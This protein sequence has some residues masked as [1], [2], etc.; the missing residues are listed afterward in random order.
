MMDT[1]FSVALHTMPARS[2]NSDTLIFSKDLSSS[3]SHKP[4]TTLSTNN[5]SFRFTLSM[6]NTSSETSLT[7]CKWPAHVGQQTRLE[8]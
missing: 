8:D 4:S 2:T 1:K 5:D 6:C 7:D 3:N